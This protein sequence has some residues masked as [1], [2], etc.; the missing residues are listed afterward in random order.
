MYKFIYTK[1]ISPSGKAL[2]CKTIILQFESGYRLWG[3]G[4]MVDTKDLKSFDS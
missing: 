3:Y 4:E 2:V 1:T